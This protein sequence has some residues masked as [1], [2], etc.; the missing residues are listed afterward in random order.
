[1]FY[2]YVHRLRKRSTCYQHS[3]DWMRKVLIDVTNPITIEFF[4]VELPDEV[5]G[6]EYLQRLIPDKKVVKAFNQTGVENLGNPDGSVMFVAGEDEEA[7]R[8]V[9][10]LSNKIDFAIYIQQLFCCQI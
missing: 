10:E 5:S 7:V 6:A 3:L 4:E 1:M 2:C 9:V 8:L